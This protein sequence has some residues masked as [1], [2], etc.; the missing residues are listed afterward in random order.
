MQG[1]VPPSRKFYASARLAG[2]PEATNLLREAADPPPERLLQEIW[3]RQRLRPDQLKTFDGRPVKVLHPGFWNREA[4]PDF[5]GAVIQIGDQRPRA[6]DV[7]IDL[8]AQSWHDHQHHRNPD[9]QN[10]LL[11]A[12]WFA[13]PVPTLLPTLPLEPAL[14]APLAELQLWLRHYGPEDFPPEL[15]GQCSAP[16]QDLSSDM[17]EKILLEAAEIRFQ[18]KAVQLRAAARQWGWEAALQRG[19]FGGLGY[20]K[21]FW[22][23]QRLAELAPRIISLTPLTLIDAQARL[24]GIAN[25]LPAQTD[26]ARPL[27]PYIRSLWNH[28]WRERDYFLEETFPREVWK[29]TG[30]RPN[31]HPHRRIGLAAHWLLR[32]ALPRELEAWVSEPGPPG[33]LAASLLKL[34]APAEDE[35]WSWHWSFSSKR[36]KRPEPLLGASRTTDLAVNVILPW[37][38]MRA[39]SAK[40]RSLQQ[41][42]EKRYRGWPAAGDNAILRLARNRL[43]GRA[44]KD[45]FKQAFHQ[46]G[47]LQIVEDFCEHSNA[48]CDKC[49]FPQLLRSLGEAGART[50][51]SSAEDH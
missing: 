20:K 18:A 46:Q 22:P 8:H 17:F 33:L 14:D 7:E 48:R 5:R 31:N 42:I 49:L 36:L 41:V 21:N 25:F 4:G 32:P 19:L 47:L 40:N 43:A 45:A 37:L 3:Y 38:W 1:K 27:P 13:Q 44:K 34:L 10:V 16:L 15:R 23:M 30:V 51:S 12:V 2:R 39:G 26:R 28:W 6:G 29:L 50:A 11:H 24:F 9:Y 35:F